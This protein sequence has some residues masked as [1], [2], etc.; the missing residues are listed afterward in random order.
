MVQQACQQGGG[1][2]V[3][4]TAESPQGWERSAASQTRLSLTPEARFTP[5]S[6]EQRHWG[7]ASK[8]KNTTHHIP[9]KQTSRATQIFQLEPQEGDRKWISIALPP[10]S[11]SQA[12]LTLE[13]RRRYTELCRLSLKGRR[14]AASMVVE[15]NDGGARWQLIPATWRLPAIDLSIN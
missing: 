9:P 12:V 2:Q 13:K 11:P 1:Y 14:L 7:K 6:M 8:K 10:R 4:Q 15:A 5:K 3:G